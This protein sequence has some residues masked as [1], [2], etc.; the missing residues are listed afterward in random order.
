MFSITPHATPSITSILPSTTVPVLTV[1]LL[2]MAD[3]AHA[4]WNDYSCWEETIIEHEICDYE[5]P[6]CE[7]ISI[8]YS[9]NFWGDLIEE[10][11]EECE[12]CWIEVEIIKN[13][14]C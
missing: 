6:I 11:T 14:I 1:A 9:R 7:V 13:Y 3:S 5:N 10:K 12:P 2:A 8:T 4:F